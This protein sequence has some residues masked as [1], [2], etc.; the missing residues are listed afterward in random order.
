MN[1]IYR[2]EDNTIQLRPGVDFRLCPFP[3]SKEYDKAL[4]SGM[5][6]LSKAAN[7]I[8]PKPREFFVSIDAR[9][10]DHLMPG[11][12]ERNKFMLVREVL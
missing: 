10:G 2:G 3:R 11:P 4:E 6:S 9:N 5:A 7:K 12:G 1:I 8:V